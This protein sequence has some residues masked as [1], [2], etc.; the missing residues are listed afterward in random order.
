MERVCTLIRGSDSL[1][2]SAVQ[3]CV[4]NEDDV[5]QL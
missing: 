3:D 4:K 2:T 1:A 5:D